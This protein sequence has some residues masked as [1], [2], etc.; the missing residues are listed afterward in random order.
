V[1]GVIGESGAFYFIYRHE[2][3]KMRRVY[4]QCE[5]ERRENDK[6]R[7]ALRER[8]LAE[9]PGAAAAQDQ[10]YRIADLAIDISQD[11]PPLAPEEIEKICLIVRE[12]GAVCA[13]SSIH[14]NCWFGRYDKISCMKD[15]LLR[16]S[17]RPLEE[18]QEKILYIGDAPN[19]EAAFRE[20]R[21]SVGVAD[22]R[23]L[24]CPPRYLSA[25]KNAEGFSETAAYVLGARG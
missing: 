7:E 18:M 25:R 23:G 19:D 16:E 14:V 3:K 8:I 24:A 12:A 4:A 10:R 17:G 11:V 2:E 9:V 6:K 5:E 13:R 15:F 21:H 22:L 1:A 20:I